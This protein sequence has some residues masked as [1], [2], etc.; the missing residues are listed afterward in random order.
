MPVEVISSASGNRRK[1]MVVPLSGGMDSAVLATLYVRAGIEVHAMFVDYGQRTIAQ[2]TKASEAVMNFLGIDRFS[3]HGI[4]LPASGPLMVP[5]AT[6]E[7]EHDEDPA[8]KGNFIPLRNL[9][10]GSLAASVAAKIGAWGVG[11]AVHDR[12]PVIYPDCTLRFIQRLSEAVNE[13]LDGYPDGP[14]GCLE[15]EAPFAGWD[16]REIA[17]LGKSIGAPIDLTWS[18]YTPGDAPCGKCGAC[19]ERCNSLS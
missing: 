14:N 4:D 12:S 16:K 3:E 15:I 1:L 9:V 17:A 19:V 11:L 2:E 10:I 5:Q 13:G 18:C 7:V 8:L 6:I